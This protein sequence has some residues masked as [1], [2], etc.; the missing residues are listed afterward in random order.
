MPVILDRT[1][2]QYVGSISLTASSTGKMHPPLEA[3]VAYTLTM[4][5]KDALVVESL[6][7]ANWLAEL[8]RCAGAEGRVGLHPVNDFGVEP[9]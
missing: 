4:E 2:N 9:G 7:V 6:F 3:V 8:L 5:R 1:R